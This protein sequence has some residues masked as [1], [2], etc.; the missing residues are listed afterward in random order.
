MTTSYTSSHRSAGSKQAY[1]GSANSSPPSYSYYTSSHHSASP[2]KHPYSTSTAHHSTS[3]VSSTF[4]T[5]PLASATLKQAQLSYHITQYLSEPGDYRSL[6]VKSYDT[7]HIE[8][9][10]KHYAELR[11]VL[12]YEW[13]G[14]GRS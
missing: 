13:E 11:N 1:N 4:C 9:K 3:D 10:Q 12:G 2:T 5:S 6:A 7:L 14:I 8:E